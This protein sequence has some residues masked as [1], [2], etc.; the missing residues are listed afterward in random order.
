M[1]LPR[2]IPDDFVLGKPVE[3]ARWIETQTGLIPIVTA[4]RCMRDS[5]PFLLVKRA[6]LQR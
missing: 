3:E 4:E 5:K 2:R 6:G 1:H